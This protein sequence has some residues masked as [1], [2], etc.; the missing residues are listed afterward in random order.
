MPNQGL[1]LDPV[2]EQRRTALTPQV[3]SEHEVQ[4]EETVFVVLEGVAHVHDE[5]VVDLGRTNRI[6]GNQET[7]N[8][9]SQRHEISELGSLE[10]DLF[11][12]P[13]LLDD[14]GNCPLFRALRLVDV[15]QS[16]QFLGPPVFHHSDLDPQRDIFS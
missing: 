6:T 5:R 4:N 9:H 12:Q 11:K 15:L 1:V 3:A 13:A 10:S 7:R 14:I 16:E 2:K 8:Q